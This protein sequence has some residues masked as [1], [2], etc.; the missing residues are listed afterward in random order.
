[1]SDHVVNEQS[2]KCPEGRWAT[3]AAWP[4]A[5]SCTHGWTEGRLGNKSIV[6]E[7]KSKIHGG[8]PTAQSKPAYRV[9]VDVKPY[10]FIAYKS[11]TDIKLSEVVPDNETSATINKLNSFN[12]NPVRD[13]AS[14]SRERNKSLCVIGRRSN[15][16]PLSLTNIQEWLTWPCEISW[17]CLLLSCPG[18]GLPWAKSQSY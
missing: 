17:L 5:D 7:I 11:G 8:M 14:L 12:T 18:S 10:V 1:M 6:S 3:M 2:V 16:A 13:Y 4:K 9:G 15:S